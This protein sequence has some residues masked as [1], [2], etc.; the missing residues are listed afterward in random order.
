MTHQDRGSTEWGTVTAHRPYGLEVTLDASGDVGTVDRM[1]I[2]PAAIYRNDEYWPDVG[3]RI[4]VQCWEERPSGLRL[5]A[6]PR[7]IPEKLTE[8]DAIPSGLRPPEWGK[9]LAHRSN[10]VEVSLEHS[11]DIGIIP[12]NLM[13]DIP[14]RCDPEFWPSPGKRIRVAR[15]GIWPNGTLR[16]THRQIF[17]EMLGQPYFQNLK[18]SHHV[19]P[20]AQHGVKSDS[21]E[22]EA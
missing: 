14:E 7:D 19:V 18:P 16:L 2:H 15:L 4:Q 20:S 10:G 12:P 9:V 5:I 3:E 22:P 11:G 8:S 21:E 17:L 13:D 1:S 6:V